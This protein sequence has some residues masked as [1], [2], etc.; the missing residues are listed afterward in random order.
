MSAKKNK[1]SADF[2]AR[3]GSASVVRRFISSEVPPEEE[4]G[5]LDGG[6]EIGKSGEIEQI[7]EIREPEGI[8][9]TR[10]T[11]KEERG[12][13]P[14]KSKDLGTQSKYY[15]KNTL[16]DAVIEETVAS[17][18]H[19]PDVCRCEKCFYD[20]CALALNEFPSY[21][22]TSEQGEL[23]R[24]ANNLLNIEMRTK[25][26]AA[27]FKAVELVKQTPMHDAPVYD[28]STRN[29]S[30][31]AEFRRIGEIIPKPKN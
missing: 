7:K 5:G 13:N 29:R 8:I 4:N 9:E 11:V 10:E 21:Y 14:Y 18:K 23:I 3:E 26:T 27:V 22:A 30:E 31:P 24:K 6:V 28:A 20:I 17:L 12:Y 1:L 25:I 15:L 19:I 2:N 16:E